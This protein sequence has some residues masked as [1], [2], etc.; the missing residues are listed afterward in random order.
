MPNHNYTSFTK[1]VFTFVDLS[2]AVPM[3]NALT[4]VITLVAGSFFGERI[5]KSKYQSIFC[6][7][8]PESA[9]YFTYR[10]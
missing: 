8:S 3:V 5:N 10:S 4:L 6:T 7:E 1:A 2:L 9:K